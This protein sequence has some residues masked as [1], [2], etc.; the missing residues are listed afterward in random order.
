VSISTILELSP[1]LATV[2]AALI[3]GLFGGVVGNILKAR[4]DEASANRRL[5]FER[6]L[7]QQE[8]VLAAQAQLLDDLTEAIWRWRYTAV[9]L[10]YDGSNCED[11]ELNKPLESYRTNRWTGLNSIRSLASRARRLIS[12]RTHRMIVDF[13]ETA[14]EIDQQIEA[15]ARLQ[16]SIKRRL[17]FGEIN[18]ALVRSVT[19]RIDNLLLGL[20]HELHLC[21]KSAPE[22]IAHADHSH[23]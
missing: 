7:T 6:E 10:T 9:Q 21:S 3:A 22:F 18:L 14:V 20:G 4:L 5:R 8:K 23:A 11:G 15:A 1:A 2:I 16:D 17:A 19:A 12:D 13:Y